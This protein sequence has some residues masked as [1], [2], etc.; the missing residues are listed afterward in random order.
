MKIPRQYR[1]PPPLGCRVVSISSRSVI[2]GVTLQIISITTCV[3]S[4]RSLQIVAGTSNSTRESI[5]VKGKLSVGTCRSTLPPLTSGDPQRDQPGFP[6]GRHLGCPTLCP[7]LLS[8]DAIYQP[9]FP[10]Q[11]GPQLP[12]TLTVPVASLGVSTCISTRTGG[13]CSYAYPIALQE[14]CGKAI[15]L[16]GL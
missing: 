3:P 16:C 14:L 15:L 6:W 11:H 5:H 2:P 1:H 13:G 4:C 12:T 9:R 8:P 7:V 10:A